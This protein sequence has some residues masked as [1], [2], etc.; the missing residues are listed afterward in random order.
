M[1]GE[2]M[3]IVVVGFIVSIAC[4]S[5]VNGHAKTVGKDDADR[6]IWVI[7]AFLFPILGVLLYIAVGL[8]PPQVSRMEPKTCKFCGRTLASDARWCDTCGKAQP[9]TSQER[10]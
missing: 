1:D 4:A 3:W 10:P 7:I 5:W 8:K 6:Y 9:A 2:W